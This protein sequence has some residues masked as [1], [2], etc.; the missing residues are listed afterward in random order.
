MLGSKKKYIV[1]I[2]K[3]GIVFHFYTKK[4]KWY[5]LC[6]IALPYS[7]EIIYIFRI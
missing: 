7:T 5:V 2:Y 1:L 4:P 6:K 3:S